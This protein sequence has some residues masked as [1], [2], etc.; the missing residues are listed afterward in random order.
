MLSTEG[1]DVT[2]RDYFRSR[3]TLRIGF[4][5]RSRKTLR[6]GFV[7]DFLNI[8]HDVDYNTSAKYSKHLRFTRLAISNHTTTIIIMQ[9]E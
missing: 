1:K 6:I 7:G 9:P 4:D 5:F 2:L 3:K 8:Q